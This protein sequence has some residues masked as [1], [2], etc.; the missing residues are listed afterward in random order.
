MHL[1]YEIVPHLHDCTY[2]GI[3]GKRI[4]LQLQLKFYRTIGRPISEHLK[5]NQ[6]HRDY[7]KEPQPNAALIGLPVDV[8]F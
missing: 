6:H 3:Y 2:N 7:L 8:I 5:L 4:K 1:Y